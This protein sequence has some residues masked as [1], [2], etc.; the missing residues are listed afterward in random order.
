[1]ALLPSLSPTTVV[2]EQSTRLDFVLLLHHQMSWA[3]MTRGRSL[4][5]GPM[6][7]SLCCKTT[8]SVQPSLGACRPIYSPSRDGPLGALLAKASPPAATT[9]T[10]S[11]TTRVSALLWSE[12]APHCLCRHR[13]SAAS[14]VMAYSSATPG[15][16]ALMILP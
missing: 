12:R 11:P 2:V 13:C 10:T 1:M 8:C 15:S 14:G 4:T 9:T 7:S 16:L 5:T 3:S 6:L